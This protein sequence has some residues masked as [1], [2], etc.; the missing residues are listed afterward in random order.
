MII[1]F[2]PFK[3]RFGENDEFTLAYPVKPALR[4]DVQLTVDE[5]R[6]KLYKTIALNEFN[7]SRSSNYSQYVPLYLLCLRLKFLA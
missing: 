3:H 7:T 2:V 4:D 5:Y 1:P 6:K